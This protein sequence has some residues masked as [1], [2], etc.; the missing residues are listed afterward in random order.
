[1]YSVMTKE[2]YTKF[3]DRW[4]RDFCEKRSHSENRYFFLL[5]FFRPEHRLTNLMKSMTKEWSNKVVHA[6]GPG[7]IVLGR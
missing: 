6:T 5:L 1:M 2:W 3:H 7:V 4:G